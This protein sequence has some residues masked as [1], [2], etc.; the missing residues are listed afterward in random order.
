MFNFFK[1]KSPSENPVVKGLRLAKLSADKQ[2]PEW[3]AAAYQ[4]YVE[5]AKRHRFF[6]TEDVRKAAKN[7]PAASN[8]SA[9]GHIAKKASKNGIMVEF[10]TMRSKSASTHGRHIIIWQSTLLS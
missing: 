9:W 5:H 8:N 3:Q 4:A 6:T 7:V 2:G 10:E 1:R